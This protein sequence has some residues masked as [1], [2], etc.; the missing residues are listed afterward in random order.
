M[1]GIQGTPSQTAEFA[2]PQASNSVFQPPQ[3]NSN[4]A[5]P[6][7]QPSNQ[8]PTEMGFGGKG[9]GPM[10][11]QKTAM[12]TPIVYGN[13]YLDQS[14]PTPT[15]SPVTPNTP[16]VPEYT[17]ISDGLYNGTTEVQGYARG[18]TEVEDPWNW[19][20]KA[21]AIELIKPSTD[22][23]PPPMADKT[24]QF[25][26]QQ[27]TAIGTNV[28][29]K[30]IDAGYKAY[31][32]AG[33]LAEAQAVSQAA[34]TDMALGGMGGTAGAAALTEAAGTGAALAEGGAAASA[35]GAGGTAMMGALSATP[36]L[37][38]IAGLFAAKN[39]GIFG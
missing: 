7:V 39:L 19:E 34:A 35:L 37:P 10:R 18:T 31:K 33:P 17:Q 30:G 15:P 20:T 12:G 3:M 16:Q 38:I 11:P 8:A 5:S 23:A 27:A 36:A 6:A 4:M 22:Q 28:A 29:T 21:P 9:G 25:L 24:E 13:T 2:N 14:Q 1:A 26:G 32:M